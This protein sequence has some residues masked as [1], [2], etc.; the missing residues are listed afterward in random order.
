[1]QSIPPWMWIVFGV[2]YWVS[3]VDVV[4]DLIVGLGWLDD[5]VFAYFSYQKFCEGRLSKTPG[6]VRSQPWKSQDA[7]REQCA[8]DHEH[9][10]DA[11]VVDEPRRDVNWS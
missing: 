9:V 5:L 8:L 2:V 4:P 11:E 1:M 7:N 6:D 3:P 10:I